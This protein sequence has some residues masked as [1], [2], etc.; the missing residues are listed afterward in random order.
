MECALVDM[1]LVYGAKGL[2]LVQCNRSVGLAVTKSWRRCKESDGWSDK[3]CNRG[4]T[5]T[6]G[7]RGSKGLGGS[8]RGRASGHLSLRGLNDHLLAFA[9][10]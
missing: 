3:G 6:S 7:S 9:L 10:H 4:G 2:L 1:A 8:L 5:Y